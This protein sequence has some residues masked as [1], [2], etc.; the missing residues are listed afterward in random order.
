M[1]VIIADDHALFRE[2][3]KSL[4]RLQEG[5]EVVAEVARA[6]DLA[7]TLDLV[8]C[9]ILLLD[10]QMERSTLVDIEA[11]T[12]R[13]AIVIVTASENIMD[14]L[15]ALRSGARGLVFKLFSV[16]TLMTAMREVTAGHVWLPPS[17]VDEITA[18]LR[19]PSETTL[20]PR[21]L[22][23][24]RYVGLGMCDADVA[25]KLGIVE[26]TV[27]THLNNI[28]Q[29][30]NLRSRSELI[31]YAVRMGIVSGTSQNKD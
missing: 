18:R 12:E 22:A 16:E 11:L 20:T 4:L 19:H 2:G 30:L 26:G 21:E 15:E 29:K 1:R 3:L 27:K 31:L 13:T 17:L 8:P 23:V 24:I 5:V 6:V 14:G 7:K 25:A 9:D 28:F 10:L